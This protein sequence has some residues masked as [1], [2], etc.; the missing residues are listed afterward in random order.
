MRERSTTLGLAPALPGIVLVVV[1]VWALAAVLMLTGTLIN[2]REIDRA[3]PIINSS[4]LPIDEDLDNVKL[5]EETARL[6]EKIRDAAAPLSDQADRIIAEAG[7][8]DRNAA[9]ILVTARSINDTAKA[10]NSNALSINDTVSTI[11]SNVVSINGLV[12]SIGAS[13]FSIGSRV[14][15]VGTNVASINRRVGTVLGAVGASNATGDGSIRASVDAILAT[16]VALE[17]VTRSIESEDELGGV[18]GINRR[19]DDGIEGA[20]LIKGD[21]EGILE[22]VGRGALQAP[23]PHETAGPG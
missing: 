10:I 22:L 9:S 18:A 2:A 17:P 14:S 16:F 3:V 12:D 13:V 15:T 20:R 1:I 6:T 5:A 23:G 11:N 21:F 8:I 19:A 7:K 4:V